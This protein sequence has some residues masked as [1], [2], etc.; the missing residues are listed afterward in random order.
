MYICIL[1]GQG[2]RTLS[3]ASPT[4]VCMYRIDLGSVHCRARRLRASRG[5]YIYIYMYVLDGL[6]LH[7][8]SR[9]SPTRFARYI[10]IDIRI[11]IAQGAKLLTGA[12]LHTFAV[13]VGYFC[14]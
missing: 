2:V 6:G 4:D 3:R 9:A 14:S 13:I 5:I 7:A 1:D 12:K 11:H 8:P 10:S